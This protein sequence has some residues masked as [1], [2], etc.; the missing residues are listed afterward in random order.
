[1]VIKI[2]IKIVQQIQ[3]WRWAFFLLIN[4]SNIIYI[5][6]SRRKDN[7]EQRVI[8]VKGLEIKYY[9]GT[10]NNWFNFLLYLRFWFNWRSVSFS[11]S[12]FFFF[13]LFL[14]FFFL[15]L[16]ILFCVSTLALQLHAKLT[17]IMLCKYILD[18]LLLFVT[19]KF[20]NLY[21]VIHLL[22]KSRQKSRLQEK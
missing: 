21:F 11:L 4:L 18:N 2:L 5:L 8:K 6:L 13:F 15:L 3:T 16:S 19:T 7:R 17:T 20:I 9:E 1:M 10:I 12:T 14:F 22:D